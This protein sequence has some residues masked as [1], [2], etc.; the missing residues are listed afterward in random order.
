MLGKLYLLPNMLY[1]EAE[2]ASSL[3]AAIAEVVAMLDGAI[4]ETE[5]PA[6]RFLGRF[7]RA[8]LPLLL[9]NEHTKDEELAELLKPLQEGKTIGLLSDAGLP[10]IADP[11]SKLV[12][13]A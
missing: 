12:A 1:D 6:R 13:R 8:Q 2:I 10:C 9:L 4:C 3:P 7:K 5:K 11:G